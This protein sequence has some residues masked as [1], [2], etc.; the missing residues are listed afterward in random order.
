MVL[1]FSQVH[2]RFTKL[3][4]QEMHL[5]P[6]LKI[7]KI[8]TCTGMEVISDFIQP[9]PKLISNVN[10]TTDSQQSTLTCYR[11][12]ASVRSDTCY[13]TCLHVFLHL[14]INRNKTFIC[15]FYHFS[16]T[17]RSNS[18]NNF[19]YKTCPPQ[20]DAFIRIEAKTG[21]LEW[22]FQQGLW[23]LN[24]NF[25]LRLQIQASKFLSP[26]SRSFCLRLKNGLVH[27]KI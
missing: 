11:H 26:T 4:L 8:W 19:H 3:W 17:L 22:D 6:F 9:F 14:P 16:Q 18:W 10:F 5:F 7:Q 15:C 13:I 25:R 27:E 2:L 24:S 12:L 20:N 1:Q 23:S 21:A